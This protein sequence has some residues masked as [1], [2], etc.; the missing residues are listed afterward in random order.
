M[1]AAE[2][3]INICSRYIE[4]NISESEG[5]RCQNCVKITEYVKMLI[6]ELKSAQSIHTILSEELNEIVNEHS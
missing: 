4:G 6:T 5:N 3:V 1:A 2:A